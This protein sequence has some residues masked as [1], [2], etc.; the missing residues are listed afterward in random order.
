MVSVAK[1][2]VFTAAKQS[3][4]MLQTE[5]VVPEAVTTSPVIS[6]AWIAVGGS[7][8]SGS[9]R[10]YSRL[11]KSQKITVLSLD[12]LTMRLYGCETAR[13]ITACVWAHNDL[14]RCSLRWPRRPSL[15][16][17][18][19]DTT[20]SSPPARRSVSGMLKEDVQNERR[21]VTLATLFPDWITSTVTY[22]Q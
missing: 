17:L 5:R 22:M 12:P 6:F 14:C 4:L 1:W 10:T 8:S 19:T 7:G 13:Q 20:P 15:R 16:C 18:H 9:C 3:P 21:G 2:D 11:D